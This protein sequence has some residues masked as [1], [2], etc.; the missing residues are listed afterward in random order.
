MKRFKITIQD[1]ENNPQVIRVA[2]V[3]KTLESKGLK[4]ASV[5]SGWIRGWLTGTTPSD[6]DIAYIGD[7]NYQ[8]AQNILTNVLEEENIEASNWDVKG[9][10]NVSED[11]TDIQSVADYYMYFYI[12]SIDCVYLGSEGKLHDL[13]G[14]GF[15]DGATRT[16]RMNEFTNNKYAYEN[17]DIVYF[18]LEGCRRITKFGWTPTKRSVDLIRYGIPLWNTLSK[19]DKNYFYNNKIRKKYEIF[20]FDRAREIYTKYG[21][22]FIFD[23]FEI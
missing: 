19:K 18:C 4:E 22:G 7:V 21:W 8:K 11:R 10:W 15:N 17:K 16:L 20:E 1:I 13:T 3:L 14:Y 12:N 23:G 6:I 2:N 9:I 5:A